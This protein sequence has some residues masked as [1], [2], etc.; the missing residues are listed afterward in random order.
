MRPSQLILPNADLADSL[1]LY[2]QPPSIDGL[3]LGEEPRAGSTRRKQPGRCYSLDGSNDYVNCGSGLFTTQNFTLSY[4]LYP[5]ASGYNH[6]VLGMG[7]AFTSGSTG[8]NAYFN[9][10]GQIHHFVN[11]GVAGLRYCTAATV[12]ANA[13][14]HVVLVVDRTLFKIRAWVNGVP[15]T[16]VSVS[17]MVGSIA[18]GTFNVGRY[19]AGYM[20]TGRFFD[21]QVIDRVLTASEINQLYV[22]GCDALPG[23][24]RSLWLKCDDQ[25]ITSAIDSS[26][27][28]RHGELVGADVAVGNFSYESNNV[29]HS[30]QNDKGYTELVNYAGASEDFGLSSPTEYYGYLLGTTASTV[31][32][33]IAN[34]NTTSGYHGLLLGVN[35]PIGV[36]T[37]SLKAKAEEYTRV[38]IC[39]LGSAR[40]W[41]WFDLATGTVHSSGGSQLI[42]GS[43]TITYAG[44]GWFRISLTLFGLAVYSSAIS[45]SPDVGSQTG[46]SANYAGTTG[47]GFLVDQLQINPGPLLPYQKTS[48]VQVYGRTIVQQPGY[49]PRNELNKAYDAFG[50]KLQYTGKCPNNAKLVNSNCL[51]LDGTDDRVELS[52]RGASDL[53]DRIFIRFKPTAAI[54]TATAAQ[55][56][57]GC[58]GASTYY[59][60]GIGNFTTGLTNETIG[61]VTSNTHREGVISLGLSTDWH[62]LEL[63]WDGTSYAI[64]V[65]GIKYSMTRVSTPQKLDARQLR[66][67]GALDGTSHF[68]GSICDVQ[69]TA[70]SGR[71]QYALAEGAGDACYD[72]GSNRYNGTVVNS[73][74]VTARATKQAVFHANL[75][76]GHT[77]YTHVSLLPLYVPFDIN[78]EPITITPP[79][80]YTKDKDYPAGVWHNYAESELDFTDGA[81]SPGSSGLD[82][83]WHPSDGVSNPIFARS[84]TV[85]GVAIRMDRILR[86]KSTLANARLLAANRFVVT[87]TLP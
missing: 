30:Y 6:G 25:H 74:I 17:G 47:D 4:W 86:N 13:W 37:V 19:T 3:V 62:T 8:L 20:F 9:S 42:V 66:I 55:Y 29:P 31:G 41:A 70:A 26:G 54:T 79:S 71:L 68:N 2:S 24:P 59:G 72:A 18:N 1:L 50:N 5:T 58:Y 46:Y 38:G 22:L 84:S 27:N 63:V 53:I 12:S 75:V 33:K 77:K 81:A 52:D 45:G 16:E 64:Y 73:N 80:G 21:L 35:R 56:L 51:T 60:V 39:D 15:G 23:Q 61:F 49:I 48:A 69:I 40:A 14:H 34:T 76:Q 36:W 85:G 65:D 57:L 83:S 78:G 87:K 43:P 7:T 28:G 82:T 67:G 10:I 11:S 32:W 44:D